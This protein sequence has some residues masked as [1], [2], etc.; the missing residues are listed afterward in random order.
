MR[1]SCAGTRH[2]DSINTSGCGFF[3]RKT[4]LHIHNGD[5]AAGTLREFGF[6]GAHKAFQEVLMEGPAPGGLSPD[7]WLEVRARF[8]AEAY[9]LKVEKS[10]KDL[11]EQEAWLRRFSE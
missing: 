6:P 7:E 10:E 8:L 3:R 9:E 5:S 2:L 11:R 4:M 1:R